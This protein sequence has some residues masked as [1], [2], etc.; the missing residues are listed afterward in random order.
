[1]KFTTRTVAAI[2]KLQM[3]QQ[4]LLIMKLTTLLIVITL[5]Q[6]SAAGYSQKVTLNEKNSPLETVIQSIKNQTGYV[7][8]YDTPDLKKASVTIRVNNASVEETLEKALKNLP[9]T[10]KII[11]NNVL[12][13]QKDFIGGK[14]EPAT[15]AIVVTGK[16]TDVKGDPLPGVSIKLKGST[17]GV[18]TG[19]D[20]SYSLT[21]PE[22]GILVFSFIGFLPQEVAT[23]GRTSINVILAEQSLALSEMVVVGYG[24]QK[25]ANLTGAVS[26]VGTKELESRPIT[27]ISSSLQ[28]LLPG[29]TVRSFTGLPGQNGSTI[30]IRGVGTLGDSGPLIV[31]DGIPGGSMDILNPDDIASISVLKDAASSSIYGVRGAN[32]VI[33]VT[34]KKGRT[35]SKPTISYNNYIGTQAP[36]ALPEFLGSPEYM[37]LLNESQINVGRT[38]TYTD[39]K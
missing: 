6:V 28:G 4:I 7:F 11:D 21:I 37:A 13:R 1:M 36:T 30:R 12:I 19:V 9:F 15:L 34:T 5:L 26:A 35:D 3:P 8:I 23:Q 14:V 38:P 20:G 18:T 33:L 27:A 39:V 10:F 22:D 29:V 2:Y 31:I 32:G 25:K 24:I 17:V 16:V